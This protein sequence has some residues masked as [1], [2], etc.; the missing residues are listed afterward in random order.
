MSPQKQFEGTDVQ[1]LLNDIRKEYGYDPTITRAETYR[2]GGVLGFFAREKYRLIVDESPAG[3]LNGESD[4]GDRLPRGTLPAGDPFALLADEIDDMVM[5]DEAVSARMATDQSEATPTVEAPAPAEAPTTEPQTAEAPS[6][7]SVLSKVANLV[8]A[9]SASVASTVATLPAPKPAE[10]VTP[11]DAI[12]PTAPTE[13]AIGVES[14][15][16]E[17]SS[18]SAINPT[19]VTIEPSDGPV[20]PVEPIE[21]VGIS[22][23]SATATSPSQPVNPPPGNSLPWPTL[24]ISPGNNWSGNHAELVRALRRTGLDRDFVA[25]VMADL[26]RGRDLTRALVDA[27]ST[28]PAPPQL[29]RAQGSLIVVA[30]QAQRAKAEARELAAE[31]GAD[32]GAVFFATPNSPSRGTTETRKIR[33]AEEATDLVPSARRRKIDLVAVDI[34]IGSANLVWAEYVIEALHPTLVLGVV[35]ATSKIED[36]AAWVEGLGGVDGLVIDSPASTVSPADLLRLSIPVCRLG[37]G[38][39]NPARW[40]TTILDRV[41]PWQ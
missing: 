32:P 8:D 20:E 9:P 14:P 31:V 26:G 18:L 21:A 38:P 25:G 41:P 10:P 12:E 16:I 17:G 6:F 35:D 22:D 33:T 36:V 37:A 13:E 40:A 34:P 30:G 19:D 5:G 39:A 29:P 4:G 27:F 7:E 23:D 24:S 2:A 11:V 3:T 1:V 15:T 28:L